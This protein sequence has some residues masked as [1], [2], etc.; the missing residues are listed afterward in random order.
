MKNIKYSTW[1]KNIAERLQKKLVCS[2]SDAQAVIETQS[3]FI[4]QSW[5]KGLSAKK[6]AKKMF[7]L[8]FD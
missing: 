3:F 4:A 5:A 7:N 8:I 1:E 2:F 6:T